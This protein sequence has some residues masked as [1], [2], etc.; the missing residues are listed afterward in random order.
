MPK[1][2]QGFASKRN[3]GK[4][5]NDRKKAIRKAK[6][7]MNRKRTKNANKAR[8]RKKKQTWKGARTT[9]KQK[10]VCVFFLLK[11][12]YGGTTRSP[13]FPSVLVLSPLR[14][15][16]LCSRTYGFRLRRCTCTFHSK[17]LPAL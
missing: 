10:Q 15:F 9:L 17:G 7:I 8:R 4:R 11:C 5:A 13:L 14:K 3:G 2:L 1:K 6:K 12:I 16:L